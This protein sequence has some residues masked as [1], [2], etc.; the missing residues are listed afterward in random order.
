MPWASQRTIRRRRA[1]D[2]RAGAAPA[3]SQP[4]CQQRVTIG[5]AECPIA[6]Y[7]SEA[8]IRRRWG[9][10]SIMS[11]AA[12]EN[13]LHY[14]EAICGIALMVASFVLGRKAM[15]HV[16]RC[17]RQTEPNEWA[18]VAHQMRRRF[19]FN[20]IVS[21]RVYHVQDSRWRWRLPQWLRDSQ[22]ATRWLQR[23]RFANFL[24]VV[25]FILVV[26]AIAGVPPN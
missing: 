10:G 25:G 23:A 17:W 6:R 20:L 1:T 16:F 12:L 3:M 15:E 24:V 8:V 5:S 22:E 7:S 18:M 14:L 21:G 19:P 13:E 11:W 2:N 4:I 26:L 9:W